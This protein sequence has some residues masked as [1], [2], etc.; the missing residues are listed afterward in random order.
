MRGITF[1]IINEIFYTS[2]KN[3]PKIMF[4]FLINFFS[5]KLTQTFI[6]S[7]WNELPLLGLWGISESHQASPHYFV[8]EKMGTGTFVNYQNHSLLSFSIFSE[9]FTFLE[10]L[11]SRIKFFRRFKRRGNLFWLAGSFFPAK[12]SGDKKWES[13]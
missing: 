9:P 5:V 11:E 7:V 3:I 4:R 8:R 6:S 13:R 10:V 1:P 12:N 2:V